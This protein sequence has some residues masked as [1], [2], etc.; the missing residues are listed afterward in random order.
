MPDLPE[1]KFS[2]YLNDPVVKGAAMVT[3]IRRYCDQ[4]DP[5]HP[6]YHPGAL[7]SYVR[8]T[9]SLN[10]LPVP[11]IERVAIVMPA[12]IPVAEASRLLKLARAC[13]SR[14][15]PQCGCAGMATCLAG[16]GKAGQVSLSECAQCVTSDT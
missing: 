14:T 3:G 10:G 4:I 12:R 11:E 1:C 15:A 16:K 6:A 2:P 5:D 7:A 13:P 8:S 9:A